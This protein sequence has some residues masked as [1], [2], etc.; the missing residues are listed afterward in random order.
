MLC[1][2]TARLDD[3]E[4]M[5]SQPTPPHARPARRLLAATI[6]AMMISPVAT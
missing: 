4:Y 3:Q 1:L 2:R 5:R 6:T